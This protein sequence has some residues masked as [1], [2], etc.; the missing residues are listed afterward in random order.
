MWLINMT[1]MMQSSNTTLI[2]SQKK[3]NRAVGVEVVQHGD[4][5]LVVLPLNLC[6]NNFVSWRSFQKKSIH[7]E[8]IDNLY[9]KHQSMQCPPRILSRKQVSIC[10]WMFVD[11]HWSSLVCNSD[12]WIE[13]QDLKW[14]I[15]QGCVAEQNIHHIFFDR[16]SLLVSRKKFQHTLQVSSLSLCTLFLFL[17]LYLVFLCLCIL[18][19]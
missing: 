12:N 2:R 4:A 11:Q 7:I 5:R 3:T 13:I 14:L 18:S 1:F 6:D 17:S 8:A 9:D 10:K 16:I 19:F 15:R